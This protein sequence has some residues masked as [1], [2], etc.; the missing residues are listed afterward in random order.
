MFQISEIHSLVVVL[1][2]LTMSAHELRFLL[3]FELTCKSEKCVWFELVRSCT[4][5]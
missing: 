2:V 3:S 4:N 1:K 5:L